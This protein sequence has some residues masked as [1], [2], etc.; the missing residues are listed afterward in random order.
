ML[1]ISILPLEFAGASTSEQP[2]RTKEESNEW[3]RD[4][5]GLADKDRA[6]RQF[7]QTESG[8]P[9]ADWTGQDFPVNSLM[10]LAVANPK[11]FCR[12]VVAAFLRPPTKLQQG[13]AARR[14]WEQ[15]QQAGGGDDAPVVD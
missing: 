5:I 4:Y 14:A 13:R 1:L 11:A 7:V 6:K 3:F 10:Q 2:H 12:L 9:A 8:S 15:R